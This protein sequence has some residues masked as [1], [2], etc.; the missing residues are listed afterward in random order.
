MTALQPTLVAY[1]PEGSRQQFTPPPQ[2][3]LPAA[4]VEAVKVGMRSQSSWFTSLLLIATVM[5]FILMLL[6]VSS[7]SHAVYSAIFCASV[8]PGYL[9][10][11]DGLLSCASCMQL[12]LC[13]S[14]CRCSTG[15]TLTSF[16]L[17][18][19]MAYVLSHV[20][21]RDI[22]TALCDE[23]VTMLSDAAACAGLC[24]SAG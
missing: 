20:H 3:I 5:L 19:R 6:L 9:A 4:A 23:S 22:P 16:L 13:C 2:H 14:W 21:K 15:A 1:S 18:S 24:C 10:L 12:L 7:C 17:S 8:T 11:R